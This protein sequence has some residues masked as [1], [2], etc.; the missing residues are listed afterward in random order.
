MK[1]IVSGD[2]ITLRDQSRGGAE[3]ADNEVV[4]GFIRKV[5]MQKEA[6]HSSGDGCSLRDRTFPGK[7]VSGEILKI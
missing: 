6:K 2:L 7:D 1:A 5:N 4:T 3:S